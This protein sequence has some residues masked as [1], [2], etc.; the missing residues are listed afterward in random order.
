MRSRWTSWPSWRPGVVRCVLAATL[1][2]AHSLAGSAT[3]VG[4]V[5]GPWAMIH[6]GWE[7][8]LEILPSDQRQ[9]GLDGAC[10]YTSYVITG[11]WTNAQGVGHDVRGRFQGQD[12]NVGGNRPCAQS[13]HLLVFTVDFR[14][15]EPPQEFMG[16]VFTH[17]NRTISG[18]TWWRDLPF[19]WFAVK[20]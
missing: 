7:G 11:K 17:G 6:D 19:G 15:G 12:P 8:T 18:L 14:N 1:A 5:V 10:T 2:M 3:G 20:K 4:D 16:Y 13:D 9:S